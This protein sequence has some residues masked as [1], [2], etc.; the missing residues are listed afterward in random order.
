M[1]T[2][3]TAPALPTKMPTFLKIGRCGY[4]EPCD[5]GDVE[6]RK[7]GL[8]V[9]GEDPLGHLRSIVRCAKHSDWWGPK[10][11]GKRRRLRSRRKGQ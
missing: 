3:H 10:F 5:E 8:R 9:T 7:S 4:A 6:C 11:P 1:P 2:D